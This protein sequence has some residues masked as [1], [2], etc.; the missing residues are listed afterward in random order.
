MHTCPA[1]HSLCVVHGR[2]PLIGLLGSH[3]AEQS[4]T[5]SKKEVKNGKRRIAP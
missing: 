1:R 3:P 5:P 4:E 2:G